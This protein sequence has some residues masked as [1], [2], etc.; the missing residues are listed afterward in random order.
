M[1]V[2]LRARSHPGAPRASSSSRTKAARR[3][4]VRNWT[5]R[6]TDTRQ[7]SLDVMID[8]DAQRHAFDAVMQA[9]DANARASAAT[10]TR[11]MLREDIGRLQKELLVTSSIAGELFSTLLAS[12]PER[13]WRVSVA[14]LLQ[15]E[16]YQ[17]DSHFPHIR[18]LLATFSRV[19]SPCNVGEA[20]HLGSVLPD[21]LRPGWPLFRRKSL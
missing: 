14:L 9:H 7:T 17:D 1:T 3:A 10:E 15:H 21:P 12:H 20:A 5:V 13:A 16:K 19:T 8:A 2:Y 11:E 4:R 18:D 6:K